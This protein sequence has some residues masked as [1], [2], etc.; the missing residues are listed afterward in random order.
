[1]PKGVMSSA[2][3]EILKTVLRNQEGFSLAAYPDAGGWSVG[4]G[5]HLRDKGMIEALHRGGALT[6]S[7]D[8][9]ETLLDRGI[10]EAIDKVNKWLGYLPAGARGAA[11]VNMAYTMSPQSLEQFEEL[12]DEVRCENWPGAAAET[13]DS[14][15]AEQVGFER[16]RAVASMLETNLWPA[17][18]SE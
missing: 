18:H 11:L 17:R 4:Y 13:L 5:W 7:R 8:A 10:D 15:W 12:L 6:I 9:A 1:M 3:K 16:S 2:D 14:R